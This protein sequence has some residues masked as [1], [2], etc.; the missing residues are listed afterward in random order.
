MK[1]DQFIKV[2]VPHVGEEEVEAVKK[3]LLSGNYASGQQVMAFESEFASYIGTEHAVAVNS[4]TAALHIAL[5]AMGI[6]RGDEVI[7]PPISFFATVSS[8]LYLGAVPVFADIDP[9][10]LCLSPEHCQEIITKKTRAILPV[11]LF[12]GSAKMDAFTRLSSETGIPVLE[13]CAQAH[14]TA[15]NGEMVG[16]FGKAGAFSFFATKHMTTGEGGIITT[17]DEELAQ[18]ARMIRSHGMSDRD[19]HK[20]LGYNNRMTEMEAA[21]G[22]IQL[23]KLPELNEKRIRNSDYLIEQLEPLPWISIPIPE[24]KVTHTYFWCP[25]MI[26]ESRTGKTIEDLKAFLRENRIGFRERYQEPLYRQGVLEKM[27]LDYSSVHLPNAESFAGKIIGIPNH[28]GLEK[29][30]LN[31]IVDI[32]KS[33]PA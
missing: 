17:N 27:G 24:K 15:F 14:G 23:K 7:V 21:M 6:A 26:N 9:D 3:V 31:K 12:G 8:V 4:G 18:Q 10:D 19:T 30:E 5:Q 28:P 2:A 11:H 16:S 33:F 20:I 22:R 1:N 25:V 32:I 13:D 29:E